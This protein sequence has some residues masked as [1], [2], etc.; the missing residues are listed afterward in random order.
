MSLTVNSNA[1]A[2]QR[3]LGSASAAV[4]DSQNKMATGK[5]I[6]SAKDDAA[7]LAI[8]T[9][10]Q[11]RQQGIAVAQR[12]ANDGLS[13][14]QTA[15]SALAQV[16]D[17]LTRMKELA[18]QAANGTNGTGDSTNLDAE[19]QQLAAEVTRTLTNAGYNGLKIMGAD[20]GARDFQIGPDSAD[21]LTV[22]TTDFTANTNITAVTG[23]D[24]TTA[25]TA[26]TAMDD[27]SAALDDINTERAMYGSIQSRFESIT[28]GLQAESEALNDSISR[29]TDVDY[30]TEMTK[31]QSN[32]VLQQAASAMLA[33][34]NQRS[35]AVLT[36]LRG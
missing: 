22:T 7:G 27:I 35:Q 20:A 29:I 9:R 23:G 21:A 4:A 10:M 19:F 28:S 13:M 16:S 24:I 36:L 15:E 2:V 11:T 31:L 18:T 32:T 17:T 33:Q 30:S 3:A 14:A 25:A 8:A 26:K 34:A 12:N 5:R 6:N 1:V